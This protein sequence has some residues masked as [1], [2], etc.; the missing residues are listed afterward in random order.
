MKK[1]F[2]AA[3]NK[4]QDKEQELEPVPK[5]TLISKVF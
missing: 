4:E 1:R 5:V 2:I 3:K